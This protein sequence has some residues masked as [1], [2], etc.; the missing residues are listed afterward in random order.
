MM[1]ELKAISKYAG[2]REDLV[3]AGGG[4]TSVKIAD[5]RMYIKASGYQLAD[6]S[7][8][9]G[10]ALV[11]PQKIV[12][13]F[14]S[15]PLEQVGKE[16]EKE[17]LD[18]AFI[19]GE[20]PSIETFLHAITDR[21]TLHTHPVSVN[22]LT[23]RST[24]MDE[25]KSLFPEAMFVPYATPGISLA[26]EYFRVWQD[27]GRKQCEI[28]FLKNHGLIISGKTAEH[29]IARNEEVMEILANY[30]DMADYPAYRTATQ[31]YTILAEVCGGGDIVYLSQNRYVYEAYHLM[32][33]IWHHEMCPDCIVYCGKKILELKDGHWEKDIKEYCTKY[34]KPAVI[35]CQDSFYI[36][37]PTVKKAKEIESIL[38]FSAQVAL[39]NFDKKM[40]ILPDTE[41]DFLLGWDAEKFRRNMK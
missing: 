32:K 34:G 33:N 13:F 1:D 4:N 21:V 14:T 19:E 38:S 30:L 24:G 11:N 2:M 12:D 27:N 28:I 7:T 23:S 41:Q 37:A 31:I 8:E 22:I 10:C 36:M 20:R 39:G 17:I 6:V 40:D 3:Q 25:L 18:R 35:K 5:E 15:M 29:V 16:Q 9:S 26:K